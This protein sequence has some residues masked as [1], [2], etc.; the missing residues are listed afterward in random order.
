MT[1]PTSPS[2]RELPPDAPFLCPH[3]SKPMNNTQATAIGRLV[4]FWHQEEG[5][6]KALNAQLMPPAPQ[7]VQ[8]PPPGLLVRPQ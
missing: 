2:A 6:N 5:C 3:C 7:R 1:N 8:A 4:V